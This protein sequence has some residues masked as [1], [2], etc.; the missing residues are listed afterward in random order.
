MR[1]S[2]AMK[3]QALTALSMIK[4]NPGKSTKE[5][6]AIGPLDHYQLARR[7]KELW[8]SG[9]LLRLESRTKDL[10]Y[11]ALWQINTAREAQSA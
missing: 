11:W 4:A 10:R 9:L 3:G 5:L 8:Q 2:G 6:G 7:S 1:E